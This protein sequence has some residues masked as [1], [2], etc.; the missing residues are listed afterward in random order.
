MSRL[1]TKSL[2][3][4]IINEYYASSSALTKEDIDRWIKVWYSLKYGRLPPT[5]LTQGTENE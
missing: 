1:T 5:W 4:F 3:E 2:S